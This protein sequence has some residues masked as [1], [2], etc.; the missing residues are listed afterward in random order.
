MSMRNLA[1]YTELL[2]VDPGEPLNEKAFHQIRLMMQE[3]NTAQA[4]PAAMVR[5]LLPK[6]T[7]RERLEMFAAISADY[8]RHCGREEI[9]YCCQCQNDE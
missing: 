4:I 7:D 2:A 9:R 3:L 5:S 8:C 6:M 1:K